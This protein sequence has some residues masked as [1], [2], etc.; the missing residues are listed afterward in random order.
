[1]DYPHLY[2]VLAL[3]LDEGKTRLQPN[4]GVRSL[5]HSSVF[6]DNRAPDYRR[7]WN[8]RLDYPNRRD[9][10]DAWNDSAVYAVIP[11]EA[12]VKERGQ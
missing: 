2:G 12:R 11:K 3:F 5:G 1:M 4:T 6:S 8:I 10:D 9:A 7:D